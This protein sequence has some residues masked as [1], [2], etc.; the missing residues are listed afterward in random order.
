V[1]A[2]E[3]NV[4]EGQ[5]ENFCSMLFNF[6][7]LRR[8]AALSTL[9]LL[10]PAPQASAQ[11]AA[12]PAPKGTAA[13]APT[14]AK[15]PWSVKMSK[16]APHTFTVKAADAKLSEVVAEISRLAKVPVTLSPSMQKQRVSLDFGGLNLDA[17]L[18][19]LAPQPVVDYE[20]GGDDPQPRPLAVYLQGLNETPPAPG[21]EMR[22]VAQ[23]ILIEGDT[24]EGTEREAAKEKEEEVPLEVIYSNSQLSVRAKK[25]P[26]SVVLY[27]IASEL[28]VPFDLRYEVPL[29]IDVE[30]NNQPLDQAV[31][32]LSPE[33][34]FYYRQ[35]LQ[36]FQIQ[37]LRLALVSPVTARS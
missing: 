17:T 25:Q 37:P 8:A 14:Q 28:G 5:E 10:L 15:Q 12:A 11:K 31:R 4:Q 6:K 30:F 19:M 2:R 23:A 18:R 33:V 32:S 22:G 34:R 29:L 35:D 21:P 16:S 26:L 27:R 36:T 1:G 9:A 7:S 24:E 13:A 20:S 3:G